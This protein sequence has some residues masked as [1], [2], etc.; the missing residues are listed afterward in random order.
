[1]KGEKRAVIQKKQPAA[2]QAP[3]YKPDKD[4]GNTASRQN[5]RVP[6]FDYHAFFSRYALTIIIFLA[7]LFFI[8]TITNPGLY[9]ND[10]WIT[11][12]QLNQ[13]NTG[14]QLV[15]SEGKYG[16][17]E[18]GTMTGYFSA[19]QNVLM[20]SLAL[21]VSAL[22]IVKLF[23]LTG[24]HFRLVV[25]LIWSLCLVLI[26]LLLETY[27]P[28]YSRIY[29]VRI[30]ILAILLALFLFLVNILLYK[31]FPFS[32]PDAPF[33]VAALVLAN[34]IF[35]ALMVAVVF[36]TCR[37]ILD[38]IW[39]TL[40]GTGA[41][42]A[43]SS[44]I[45]W[46]GTAKDH[47]L[48]ATVFACVI[49]F[50]ILW[51]S[52]GRPRHALLTFIGCGLLIWVRPEVGFFVTLFTGL[53]FCI[54]LTQKALIH[55]I[56]FRELPRLCLPLTG[57]FLGAVPF[58]ANNLL[59]S[60]NWLIPAFDLPRNMV[61]PAT[62]VATASANMSATALAGPVPL[63]AVVINEPTF[64][65]TDG[66]NIFATLP[67]AWDMITHAMF[68]GFTFDNSIQGFFG[69]MLF[70]KNDHIGFLI[71]CPLIFIALIAFI[72][73]NKKISR[74]TKIQ[75]ETYLFL[76][77]MIFAAIFSYL[78]TLGAMNISAGVVPDMRY[79]SPAYLPCGLISIL[80]L[81]KTPFFKKPKD[82]L[83]HG[84]AGAVI[85]VPLLLFL[86][87][88]VHPFG[89]MEEGYTA[90]FKFVIICEIILCSALMIIYRFNRTEN[91]FLPRA[92]PH[93]I[94]FLI[95]TVFAFQIVLVFFIGVI[96]KFNGYPLWIPL[97]RE[98]FRMLF[99]VSV[100][101]PV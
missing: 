28:S 75:R 33:E 72:L 60:H 90:F 74:G 49:W 65:Q 50:F 25:I 98:I 42:I 23:S 44:Y 63:P 77:V 46:A 91:R 12:N 34:N 21:P 64:S 5:P 24:D 56:P 84:L 26:A 45:F 89:I 7:S 30:L 9:M 40:F 27:Y 82:L 52:S 32:A 88:V 101:P 18:N 31:Q 11:A 100:L 39:M 79:L 47:M 62:A 83:R 17:F 57:V 69:V 20:Y 71:L 19:R 58:F 3:V 97:I 92:L 22:P 86:M 36:E 66:L 93:L 37:V 70:P 8:L 61:S 59:V 1:M 13:I 80:L 95:I 15:F 53:F 96:I 54:L 38:D 51:L 81:S 76:L 29:G 10:E 16:I 73:W 87:I 4:A 67:R 99:Q 2:L 55:E 35:F 14:H 6:F 78:P 94:L 43:C 48:T 85:I 41:V 68:N